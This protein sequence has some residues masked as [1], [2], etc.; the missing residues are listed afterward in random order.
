MVMLRGPWTRFVRQTLLFQNASMITS[1]QRGQVKSKFFCF[2]RAA[3]RSRL[4][5]PCLKAA[6]GI[7]YAI[8]KKSDIVLRDIQHVNTRKGTLFHRSA[9]LI[10][11]SRSG[12][13][14]KGRNRHN[15]PQSPTQCF[16][17]ISV[18]LANV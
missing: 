18:T 12:D 14:P 9:H 15:R 7:E 6:E 11:F 17:S 3:P 4:K 10:G 1:D 5:L 8:P 2:T 13:F 16:G